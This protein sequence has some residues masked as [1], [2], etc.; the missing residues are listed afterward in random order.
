MGAVL[1]DRHAA[2]VDDRDAGAVDRLAGAEQ[3]RLTSDGGFQVGDPEGLMRQAADQRIQG[4]LRQEAVPQD[5]E[6]ARIAGGEP[7]RGGA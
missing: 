1:F 2:I 4:R 7:D 6:P 3:N 5:A